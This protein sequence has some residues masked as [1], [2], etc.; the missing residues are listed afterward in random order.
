VL[1]LSACLWESDQA[2]LFCNRCCR[3]GIKKL[4]LGFL[5]VIAKAWVLR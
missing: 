3:R 1:P 5:F 2:L 4:E